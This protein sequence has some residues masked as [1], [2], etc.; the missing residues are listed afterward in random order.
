MAGRILWPIAASAALAFIG[1][2]F[3]MGMPGVLF[4]NLF[5]D[6][7]RLGGQTPEAWNAMMRVTALAP[8]G[9]PPAIWALW[10]VR[11]SA[12][13]MWTALAGAAGY[14]CGGCAAAYF[15]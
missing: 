4:L 14:F 13:W 5:G 9:A 7:E 11:P 2:M 15:A 3:L 8:A 6:M 12:R 1:A 10:A